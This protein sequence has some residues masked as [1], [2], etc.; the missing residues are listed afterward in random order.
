MISIDYGTHLT[1]K[2]NG[3]HGH[4]TT[5][6][7]ESKAQ[8]AT[9]L[10]LVDIELIRRTVGRMP[11]ELQRSTYRGSHKGVSVTKTRFTR[12]LDPAWLKRLDRG[13]LVTLTRH[14]ERPLDDDNLRDAFKSIRDGV[15]DAFGI[16]DDDKRIRFAYA[17]AKGSPS[18]INVRIDWLEEAHVAAAPPA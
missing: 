1:A 14:A 16:R 11:F 7:R 17:Q 2:R 5:V 18:K 10:N 6:A 12:V 9:M 4:W 3:S 13:V 8:R 15:A